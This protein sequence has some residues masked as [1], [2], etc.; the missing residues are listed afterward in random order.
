MYFLQ[1]CTDMSC[2][3]TCVGS[4]GLNNVPYISFKVTCAINFSDKETWM[5]RLNI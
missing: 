1:V 5:L 2:E 4:T 3:I